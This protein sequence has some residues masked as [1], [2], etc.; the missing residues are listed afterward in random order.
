[1]KRLFV[2][3]AFATAALVL[4][5]CGGGSGGGSS[6]MGS[7]SS[8]GTATTVATKRVDGKTVLV[9]ADGKAL[10]TSDQEAGGMVRCTGA[11]LQF[12]DPLTVQGGQP[13]GTVTGGALGVLTRPDGKTQVTFNGAPVYR[14]AEDQSGSLK[15]DGFGDAF[16]GQKFTWHA[17]TTGAE[18]QTPA[19]TSGSGG[20]TSGY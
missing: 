1:M 7:S 11:C 18:S 12:W 5:A 4:A 6:S 3:A 19:T 13:T 14:F 2:L 20:G 17:V 8:R 9:D 15:G 10:Y 16:A